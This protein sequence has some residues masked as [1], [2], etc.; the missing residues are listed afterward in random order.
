MESAKFPKAKFTGKI[1]TPIDW[2]SEKMVVAEIKG[3]LTMHGATKDMTIKAQITPGK[4]KIIATSEL[5][6]TPEDFKI[7]IP[8][9]VRDKIAKE[10]T[11]KIEAAYAPYQQ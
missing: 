5:K 8:S 9:A 10:V 4:N 3:Q 2:K 11:I 1:V 7:A 6:V